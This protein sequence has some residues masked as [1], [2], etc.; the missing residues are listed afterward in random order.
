MLLRF[1]ASACCHQHQM[2]A[3]CTFSPDCDNTGVTSTRTSTFSREGLT[4]RTEPTGTPLIRT[5]VPTLIPHASGN[6]RTH[7]RCQRGLQVVQQCRTHTAV[8]LLHLGEELVLSDLT[9]ALDLQAA[10]LTRGGLVYLVAFPSPAQLP[11]TGPAGQHN[12]KSCTGTSCEVYLM[13]LPHEP[14]LKHCL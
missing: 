13:H 5:G 11:A 8:C 1:A 7:C 10:A 6:S 9:V 2:P 14:E 12:C 4:V 3:C